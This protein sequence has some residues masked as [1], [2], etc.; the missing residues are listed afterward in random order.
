MLRV[1][2][3]GLPKVEDEV[4]SVVGQVL[5]LQALTC[6]GL[7]IN[8]RWPLIRGDTYNTDVA[9]DKEV[10]PPFLVAGG[11]AIR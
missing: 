2:G 11:E 6:Q 8:L 1:R 3:A 4:I 5:A 9:G 7:G 10:H